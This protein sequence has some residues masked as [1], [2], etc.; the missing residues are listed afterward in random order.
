MGIMMRMPDEVRA[1]YG[2]AAWKFHQGISRETADYLRSRGLETAQ[3]L[4]YQLGT[5]TS[6]VTGYGD[7][8]G[9]VSVPYIS[10]RGGIVNLK[11]RQ[12]HTCLETCDHPKYLS[13]GDTRLFN[14]VVL[15]QADRMGVVGLVEGEFNAIILTE[16]CGIPS[17]GIPGAKTWQ[18]HKEWPLIFR[19]YPRVLMFRDPDDEGRELAKAIGR[20]VDSRTVSLPFDVNDTF[21]TEGRRPEAIRR[22]AGLEG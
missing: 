11:F 10:P 14:T 5:V 18:A 17:V 7:Y 4:K 21:L 16:F 9:M 2:E 12:P 13:A 19:G 15:D 8:E 6:E 22:A 3:I 20:S 1:A